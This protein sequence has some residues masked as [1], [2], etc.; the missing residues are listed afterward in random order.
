MKTIKYQYKT[1][2][3]YANDTLE[4]DKKINTHIKNGWILE[5]FET[6]ATQSSVHMIYLL[7]REI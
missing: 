2:R 3:F 4:A 7:K 1:F 6:A 5:S